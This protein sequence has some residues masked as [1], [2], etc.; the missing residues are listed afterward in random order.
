M[1]AA[2][3]NAYWLAA[4]PTDATRGSPVY[5]KASGG[6]YHALIH[7][8]IPPVLDVACEQW[9]EDPETGEMVKYI[10]VERTE[11]TSKELQ[12]SVALYNKELA[13]RMPCK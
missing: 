12:A 6:R 10:V 8:I 13:R 3:E 4:T 2:H 9:H 1:D 11:V 7:T 5:Y